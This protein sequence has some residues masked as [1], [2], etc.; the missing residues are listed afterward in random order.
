MSNLKKTK[1]P[2]KKNKAY[3]FLIVCILIL[4]LVATFGTS[5][6]RNSSHDEKLV[7][8]SGL[9]FAFTAYIRM[10]YLYKIEQLN[11]EHR[12]QTFI[13]FINVSFADF[14]LDIIFWIVPYIKK[15]NSEL[16]EKYRKL[17]N[18][19]TLLVYFT[20]IVFCY[21]IFEINNP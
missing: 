7:I 11:G 13:D 5:A 10:Y 14:R 2:K 8:L 3:I 21:M 9:V 19:A 18:A 4:F 12:H 16:L 1:T 20:L 17:L 15:Y 6:G